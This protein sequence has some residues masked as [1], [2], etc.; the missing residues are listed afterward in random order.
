MH[1]LTTL[2][3]RMSLSKLFVLYRF[4][5]DFN[6]FLSQ[7]NISLV[8]NYLLQSYLPQSILIFLQSIYWDSYNSFFAI[9]DIHSIRFIQ[10]W[11]ISIDGTNW[12]NRRGEAF[13]HISCFMMSED[14]DSKLIDVKLTEHL[15]L[16]IVLLGFLIF[17][18]KDGA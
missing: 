14:L 11:I 1:D 9:L 17:D 3:W 6:L 13:L 5:N 16:T 7:M 8:L 12:Q 10:G 2:P 4:S 18:N 15:L